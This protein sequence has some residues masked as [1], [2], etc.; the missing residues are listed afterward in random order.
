MHA[1]LDLDS[2]S[3]MKDE[4]NSDPKNILAQNVV[5]NGVII[6]T[7]TKR[8]ALESLNNVFEFKVG[9]NTVKYHIANMRRQ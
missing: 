4:F 6:D 5:T 2:L 7:I 9:Y 8:K 3:A 1:D